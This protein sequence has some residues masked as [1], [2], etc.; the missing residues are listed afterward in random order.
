MPKKY[1]QNLSPAIVIMM[2][3]A[4]ELK[5]KEN[6]GYVKRIPP[7][8]YGHK[9]LKHFEGKGIIKVL[10]QEEYLELINEEPEEEEPEEEEPEEEEPE[11]EEPEEEEPEEEEVDEE[12]EEEEVD[13][14]PEEEE[15]DEEPEEEEVE[16][17]SAEE[18]EDLSISEKRELIKALDLG[19]D[20]NMLKHDSMDSGYREFLE[21][22]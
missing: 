4:L 21:S 22:Q 1:A 7:T 3:G 12:P 17:V 15:V 5:P 14:E 20:V 10:S 18:F 11:E 16:L 13:E 6:P 8:G 19:D 2:N 9:D